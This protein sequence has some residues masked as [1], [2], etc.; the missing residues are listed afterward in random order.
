MN[1]FLFILSLIFIITVVPTVIAFVFC[2]ILGVLQTIYEMITNLM[3]KKS[4]DLIL[5]QVI[6][7]SDVRAEAGRLILN[8]TERPEQYKLH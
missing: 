6:T 8:K 4:P 3:K 1:I 7:K 5:N 2:F